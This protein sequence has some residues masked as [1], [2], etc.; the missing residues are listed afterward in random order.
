MRPNSM[1]L[2]GYVGEHRMIDL[3]DTGLTHNFLNVA[4][5]EVLGCKAHLHPM[6]TVMI[7][8]GSRLDCRSIC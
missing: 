6:F 3:V 7:S 5:V 1:R 4:I 2:V 8:D